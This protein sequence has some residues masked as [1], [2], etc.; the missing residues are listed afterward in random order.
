M[1]GWFHSALYIVQISFLLLV[2]GCGGKRGSFP[3]S[4]PKERE[5]ISIAVEKAHFFQ[6]DNRG[7]KL[8][9]IWADSSQGEEGQLT[10][11]GIKCLLYQKGEPFAE[12]SAPFAIYKPKGGMLLLNKGASLRDLASGREMICNSLEV[13][14]VNRKIKG[15][16][17]RLKW[18][19][20]ELEG[21]ELAADWGLKKGM[22]RNGAVVKIKL[23]RRQAK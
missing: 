14:F 17:V 12:L 8:G 9:E 18:G 10:L 5:E 22:L 16:G 21:K 23:K 13:L 15:A 11:K 4:P 7:R 1:E 2:A 3:T 19:E 20:V 6:T